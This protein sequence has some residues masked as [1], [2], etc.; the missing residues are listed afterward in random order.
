MGAA[1]LVIVVRAAH[2]ISTKQALRS[3][4]CIISIRG[5]LLQ[6]HKRFDHEV[7]QLV[8][9]ACVQRV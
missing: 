3:C 5:A 7:P 8:H 2:S 4:W 1:A 9:N 6:V